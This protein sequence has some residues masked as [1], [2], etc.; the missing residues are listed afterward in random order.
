MQ[1]PEI[2]NEITF[3][4]LKG[5]ASLA[6][7]SPNP[8]TNAFAL[9]HREL[10]LTATR[11]T[12][13]RGET[14]KDEL[15]FEAG[16]GEGVGEESL[17][18]TFEC[19]SA[20]VKVGTLEIATDFLS[21][22]AR[23]LLGIISSRIGVELDNRLLRE[24][25]K[26]S[27][28]ESEV[29]Q[30]I[31]REL[32]WSRNVKM[33]LDLVLEEA[34]RITEADGGAIYLGTPQKETLYL[35]ATRGVL[36]SCVRHTVLPGNENSIVGWVAKNKTPLRV[37]DDNTSCADGEKKAIV[38]HLAVPLISTRGVMG[39]LILE[40]SAGNR[41]DISHERVLSVFAAQASKA[42]EVALLIGDLRSERDT[43]ENILAS[44][45]NG[46][47]ATDEER[48]VV[49]MN[50]AAR[51][52]LKVREE[53]KGKPI[54]RYIPDRE[55]MRL[56]EKV[57]SDRSQLETVEVVHGTGEHARHFY[58]SICSL[59]RSS[60]PGAT[61]IIQNITEQK[62]LSNKMQLM[63]RVAS[64]GQLAAGIA[65]EI[66]NPLTGIA[67][68][69]DNLMEEEAF[70]ESGRELI[71]D[72]SNEVERLE[73]L[74]RGILDFASPQPAKT[75]PMQLAKALEW[76]R[77]FSEQCKKKGVECQLLLEKNP[78]IVGDPEKL[79]QLFLNLSINALEATDPGGKV[80]I[81]TYDAT[82]YMDKK[83]FTVE[84]SD[85][86][87]GMDEETKRQVFNPFFTTKNE[88][89][90]L[91]L[92]IVHSICEQH[93]GNIEIIST[94]GEGTTFVV[95]LPAYLETKES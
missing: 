20:S 39:V 52:V 48:K 17:H 8:V 40:A 56:L 73:L 31:S 25:L 77:T 70:S 76:H 38:N 41:F 57:L 51:E 78:K 60:T 64:I 11:L 65:H 50:N 37:L 26:E 46:I 54:G 94:P 35:K 59:G 14:G 21:D 93:G 72:I 69:L 13:H 95:K 36:L 84:I 29:I 2:N 91:G 81:K 10:G 43:R 66:R 23:G 7:H 90:G 44:T 83:Y 92:S 28:L 15:L 33:V 3:R 45:P 85:T 82:P 16:W 22:D 74:I 86:G 18:F 67:I 49:L 27:R 4:L 6:G 58:V 71:G 80:T 79:K 32:T 75:R 12:L 88:G 62:K 42:I 68:T 55:V 9:L 63:E 19:N 53:P 5:F 24:A 61:L 30:G 34:L 1:T 47:I 87:S 89:T